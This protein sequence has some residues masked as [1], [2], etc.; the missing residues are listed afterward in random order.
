M[1]YFV[2]RNINGQFLDPCLEIMANVNEVT[3]EN[4]SRIRRNIIFRDAVSLEEQLRNM[5]GT[6]RSLALAADQSGIFKEPPL[7][8]V[9]WS[10]NLDIVNVLL[11]Y[12]AEVDIEVGGEYHVIGGQLSTIS[13]DDNILDDDDC[14]GANC[15][16]FTCCTPL[17]LA[18]ARGHLDVMRCLIENG[19][20]IKSQSL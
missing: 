16:S 18:A 4:R 10:E 1:S 8:T 13:I 19:A 17:F 15:I 20:D 2:E 3:L 9:V 14:C 7:I 5:S 6:E 12:K 11:K